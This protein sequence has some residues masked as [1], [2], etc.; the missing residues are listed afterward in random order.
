MGLKSSWL[1]R[2]V[3]LHTIFK[4]WRW[5]RA[6]FW[7]LVGF[8][9]GFITPYAWYLDKQVRERFAQYRFDQPSRVYARP[10]PLRVGSPLSADALIL[11]L[12]AA[13]YT[14]TENLI[15]QPGTYQRKNQQF[16]IA[17]RPFH[18]VQGKVPARR[19][20]LGVASNRITTLVDADNGNALT[21]AWIDPA[22]IATLYGDQQI[23]RKWVR[24]SD[25]PKLVVATLQ[26]VEDRSFKDHHGIDLWAIARAMWVNLIAGEV[27]QGGSTLTQQLVRN[28]F[29]DRSQTLTRKGNEVI[30]S[31]LIEARFSKAAI[32]EAY[33]NEVYLGQQ[34]GQAIHGFAAASEFYFGRELQHLAIHEIALLVGLIQGPSLHDPRRYPKRAKARRAIVLKIMSD[35]ALISEMDRTVA[36][37]ATLGVTPSGALPRN[38]YPAFLDIV[39]EQLRREFPDSQL[40][41]EGLSIMTTLAPS[42]QV[43]TEKAVVERLQ[44]LGKSGQSLQAAVVVTE[45]KTGAVQ[46]V[47]GDRNP[48]EPGFNRAI[49]A[50]RPIGSLVKPFIYLIALAQPEQWSLMSILND[51]AVTLRQS[52]GRQWSP[53]N[54]DGQEHGDIA[55]IDAL[56]RSYNLATVNLGVELGVSK[57]ARVLEALIPGTKISELPSILL[58]SIDLSPYQMTQAYQYLAADG[59]PTALYTLQAVFDN[60][61]A[62]LKRYTQT[63]NAGDLV[64]ASRLVGFALQ[65]TARRGTASALVGLGLAQLNAAGKTGT[66][67][68]QR[69]SWFAG[70]TGSHLAVVWLGTDD[71]HATGLYGATGAMRVWADLFAKLPT[72]PLTLNLREDPQLTWVDTQMQ[73]LTLSSC[74]GA[75]QLPFIKGY[76]PSELIDCYGRDQDYREPLNNDSDNPNREQPR[77]KRRRW[78][79]WFR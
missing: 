32:L 51:R 77:K 26:A 7:L 5:L 57:V 46:A 48:S 61:G 14:Q 9:F 42:T 35:L 76:E 40:R 71:N 60:K 22:R 23:E 19:I 8:T 15:S 53:S 64:P 70:Y 17:T 34:G 58:G 43:Y 25:V 36:E 66:S 2:G 12:S 16:E 56:A 21:E 10:L 28:L 59:H 11:E 54:S 49:H 29:L 1:L 63:P 45:S 55:L 73:S 50:A 37:Q 47:V 68:D 75:R 13:R 52:N 72:M 38:R 41:A 78:F 3:R 27:V 39:K 74:E 44:R 20:K 24:A 62:A 4:L 30:I 65:E 67:N 69:D 79:D 18:G 31:L 33:L 6:P